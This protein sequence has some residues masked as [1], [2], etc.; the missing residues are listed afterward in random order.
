[1]NKYN[2]LSNAYLLGLIS[3]GLEQRTCFKLR[4]F[5]KYLRFIIRTIVFTRIGILVFDEL[6]PAS[7]GIKTCYGSWTRDLR[8][9]VRCSRGLFFKDFLRL[10]G[11]L[12]SIEF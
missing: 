8:C 6:K 1:M 7:G 2:N 9:G 10:A 3:I 11:L 5:A 4:Y 12:H